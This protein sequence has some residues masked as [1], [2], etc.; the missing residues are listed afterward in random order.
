MLPVITTVTIYT[1]LLETTLS[2]SS[3][4]IEF[5]VNKAGNQG[6]RPVAEMFSSIPKAPTF[7]PQTA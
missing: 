3:E 1:C 7:T 5:K 6:C 4:D 2:S